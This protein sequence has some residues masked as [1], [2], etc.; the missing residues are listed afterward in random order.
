MTNIKVK[1]SKI[2]PFK[3]FLACQV[4]GTIYVRYEYKNQCLSKTT[5]N[6]ESIH[7]AQALDF[8]IGKLGFI[9]FYFLYGL[10]WV[11]RLPGYLWN[12]NPYYEL[13]F[14]REAY[15]NQC[16]LDYLKTRKRFSWLKYMFK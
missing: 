4:F 16:N 11:L 2:I 15:Y 7:L 12:K 10:E 14:E 3:G 1:Y 13:S 8:G 9:P 5:I 6:H